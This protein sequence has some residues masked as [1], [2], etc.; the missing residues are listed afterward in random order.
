[1]RLGFEY[2]HISEKHYLLF[3]SLLFR[4]EISSA[5]SEEM[6]TKIFVFCNFFLMSEFPEFL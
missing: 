1:M 6:K 2:A 5:L 4:V 3:I